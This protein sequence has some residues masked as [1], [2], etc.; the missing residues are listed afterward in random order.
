KKYIIYIGNDKIKKRKDDNQLFNCKFGW[1]F[2]S[3]GIDLKI[4]FNVSPKISP[5]VVAKVIQDYELSFELF[6]S[7]RWFPSI[8]KFAEEMADEA[9]DIFADWI[10][11]PDEVAERLAEMFMKEHNIIDDRFRSKFLPLSIIIT[12]ILVNMAEG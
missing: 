10:G 5:N 4:I 1:A 3:E 8:K 11:D 12:E 9:S 6:K 7:D 2:G